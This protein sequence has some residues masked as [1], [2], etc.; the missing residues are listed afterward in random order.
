[1]AWEA[2]EPVLLLSSILRPAHRLGGGGE[3]GGGLITALCSTGW[4]EGRIELWTTGST[5]AWTLS[6]ASR[7]ELSFATALW[8]HWLWRCGADGAGSGAAQKSRA[9]QKRNDDGVP[10]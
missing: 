1:M 10:D 7:L 8:Q 6:K 3:A 4:I 5:A 9:Q 2:W